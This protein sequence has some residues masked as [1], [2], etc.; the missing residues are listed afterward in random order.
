MSATTSV[1]AHAAAAERPRRHRF[2]EKSVATKQFYSI[3]RPGT[4]PT[5]RRSS[6]N[7]RKEFKML[8][9]AVVFLVIAL[10]AGLL[11]FGGIAGASAGIAQILFFVF[12]ALLVLSLIAGLFRRA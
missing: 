6:S 10:V 12:L 4:F 7:T 8:Y 11:G 9:Y 3:K 1:T 5:V 2:M